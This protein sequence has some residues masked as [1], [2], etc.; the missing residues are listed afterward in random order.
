MS[1]SFIEETDGTISVYRW[2]TK[3]MQI[4]APERDGYIRTTIFRSYESILL[5]S[6]EETK[7][8]ILKMYNSHYTG[9]VNKK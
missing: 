8:Y 6:V 5:P 1:I 2:D 3:I 9:D 4:N 7:N